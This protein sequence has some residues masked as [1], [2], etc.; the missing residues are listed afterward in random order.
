MI[1]KNVIVNLKFLFYLSPITSEKQIIP[2]LIS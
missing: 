2:E 1:N